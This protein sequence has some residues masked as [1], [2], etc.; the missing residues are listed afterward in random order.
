M[1]VTVKLFARA[2]DLAGAETIDVQLP[3]GATIADL[4]LQLREQYPSLAGLIPSLLFA[5]GTDYID[6]SATIAAD[7]DLA[8]FPPVSGG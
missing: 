1:K 8:C 6:D 3:V 4:R 7:S 2:R 5:C